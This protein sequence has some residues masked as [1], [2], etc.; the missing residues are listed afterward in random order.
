MLKLDFTIIS[1][2]DRNAFVNKFFT[3]NPNY[4]PSAHELDTI[5]NYILYG[6]DPCI[7]KNGNYVADLPVE[8]WTNMPARKEIAIPTKYDSWKEKEPASLDEV[9]E[10]PSF[11]ESQIVREPVITKAPKC[12]F[13][14]EHEADIPS[15]Q[16]LWDIIDHY[17]EKLKDETLPAAQKYQIKHMLIELRRQ[18]FTLKDIFKP[19]HQMSTA[20][21]RTMYFKRE[22]EDEINWNESD[23]NFGCAPMGFYHKG[24]A[25][26]ENPLS[27]ADE[28]DDWGYNLKAKVII[29]FRNVDH[30]DNIVLFYREL[31]TY[32]ADNVI[33]SQKSILETF[34]FYLNNTKLSDAQLDII[35]YK[36]HHVPNKYIAELINHAY[37]K[38]YSTNY[39]S[40]IYRKICASIAA[41]AEKYYTYY[42]ERINLFAFKRCTCCGKMKLRNTEE[43]TRKSR[44]SDGFSSKCK[45]CERKEKIK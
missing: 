16:E 11:N 40:T 35:Y 42:C 41:T 44:N 29:D 6:K 19:T 24:D 7:D 8:K 2:E 36:K 13:D 31:E 12:V 9:L 21:N 39:I 43:F 23:S 14:R 18:Q 26:F 22:A 33:T 32:C 27:L 20:A 4:Q 10:S 25:R 34:D 15:I 38:T 28:K 37:D 17:S 45:E 1:T 30:I 5:T 3:D